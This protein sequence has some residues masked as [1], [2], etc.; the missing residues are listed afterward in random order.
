MGKKICSLGELPIAEK[1]EINDDVILPIYSLSKNAITKTILW[2]DF[3]KILI[4][5]I[6]ENGAVNISVTT[7]RRTIYFKLNKE[8]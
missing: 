3:K 4:K 1:F 2:K 6:I 7:D 8:K 5:E